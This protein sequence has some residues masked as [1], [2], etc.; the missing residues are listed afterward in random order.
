MSPLHQRP[1]PGEETDTLLVNPTNEELVNRALA[2]LVEHANAVIRARLNHFADD[3][4]K[5]TD[6]LV[7]ND[8][9]RNGRPGPSSEQYVDQGAIRVAAVEPERWFAGNLA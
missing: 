3:D 4:A 7:A 8:L 1:R 5:W 6:V 2:I 9:R